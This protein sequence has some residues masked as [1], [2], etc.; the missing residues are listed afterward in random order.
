VTSSGGENPTVHIYWGPA[1]GGTNPV[2]WANDVNLGIKAAGSFSKNISGLTGSNTYFYRCFASNSVG[3]AWA[4]ST[5]SFTTLA[6]ASAPVIT[7]GIGATDVKRSSIVWNGE[8]VSTGGVDPSVRIYYGTTDGG[9]NPANWTKVK[10]L[11]TLPVG[12][13]SASSTGL[14]PNTTYYYRCWASNA[15]GTVWAPTSFTV[16]T[17][18]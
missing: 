9:T 12:P 10:Y 5:T 13:F 15:A 8:I 17:L 18:P 2:N 11:S 7:N 14:I 6:G 1:D 3:S 16:T 4:D